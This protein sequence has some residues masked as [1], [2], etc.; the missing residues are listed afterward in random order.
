[1]V[2]KEVSYRHQLRNQKK[3][4]ASQIKELCLKVYSSDHIPMNDE[5]FENYRKLNELRLKYKTIKSRLENFGKRKDGIEP[6]ILNEIKIN[7]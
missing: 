4:V 5:W 7:K 2:D 6:F 3:Q 1:M